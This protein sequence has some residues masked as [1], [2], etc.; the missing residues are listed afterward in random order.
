MIVF[1][2][3]VCGDQLRWADVESQVDNIS[4]AR[5]MKLKLVCDNCKAENVLAVISS[6]LTESQRHV[7]IYIMKSEVIRIS[8]YSEHGHINGD[9]DNPEHVVSVLASLIRQLDPGGV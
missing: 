6:F 7:S 8:V 4:T 5:A 3:D 1:Y 2:C 9:C